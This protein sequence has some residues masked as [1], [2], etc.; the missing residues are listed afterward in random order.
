MASLPT[1][2]YAPDATSLHNDS[3]EKPQ[4]DFHIST[5]LKCE[6]GVVTFP[7]KA[8]ASFDNIFFVNAMTKMPIPKAV[9]R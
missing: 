2:S 9:G 8:R 1:F 5:N 3:E 7:L 4:H 6:R